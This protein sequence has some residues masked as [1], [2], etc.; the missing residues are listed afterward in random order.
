MSEKKKKKKNEEENE[1]EWDE[2]LAML[3]YYEDEINPYYY[4]D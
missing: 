4:P 1:D 3:E 2:W